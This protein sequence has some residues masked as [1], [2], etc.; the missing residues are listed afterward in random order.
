MPDEPPAE[1][2]LAPDEAIAPGVRVQI[3]ATEHWSLLA[4]RSTAQAEVLSRIAI[5]LTFVSATRS[6]SRWSARRPTS[7]AG[8]PSSRSCC[9][10]S[11]CWSAP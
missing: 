9:C 8:S 4:T 5:L 10:A 6:A 3:L 7:T 2:T 1:P 11:S